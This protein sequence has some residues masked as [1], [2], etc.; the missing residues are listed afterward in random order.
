[1]VFILW[2]QMENVQKCSKSTKLPVET[3]IEKKLRMVHNFSIWP[4]KDNVGYPVLCG[5]PYQKKLS[6]K[7]VTKFRPSDQVEGKFSEIL[8]KPKIER[9]TPK[10]KREKR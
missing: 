1:M 6:R 10:I 4:H 3:L 9:G 5:I 2:G 8:T 7:K